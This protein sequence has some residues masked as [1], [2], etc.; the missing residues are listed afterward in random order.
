VT[1]VGYDHDS[2][3]GL[4]YWIVKNSWGKFWGMSGYIWMARNQDN[5]CGIATDA[6]F[7]W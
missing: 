1:V 2:K 7:P 3:S 5:K 4:D 6:T